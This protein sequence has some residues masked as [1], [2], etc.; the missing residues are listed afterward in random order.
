MYMGAGFY[1]YKDLSTNRGSHLFVE[2]H[3][4]V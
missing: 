2:T 4:V 1:M 3:R